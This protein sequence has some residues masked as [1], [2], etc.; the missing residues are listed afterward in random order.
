MLLRGVSGSLPTKNNGK[1]LKNL[2]PLSRGA[3]GS[4]PHIHIQFVHGKSVL[5]TCDCACF[6]ISLLSVIGSYY[7]C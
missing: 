6:V 3:G 2:K 1:D 7:A 5:I 4:L